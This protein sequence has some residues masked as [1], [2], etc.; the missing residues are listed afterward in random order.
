MTSGF[1][2][3]WCLLLTGAGCM[4]FTLLVAEPLLRRFARGWR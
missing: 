1:L 3:D 2:R 4:L